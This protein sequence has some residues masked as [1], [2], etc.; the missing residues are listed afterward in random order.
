MDLGDFIEQSREATTPGELFDLLVRAA[1]DL[2]FER[3]AYGALTSHE[4]SDFPGRRGPAV[5]LNYPG[6]WQEHYFERGYHLIDP[7]VIRTPALERPYL[8]SDMVRKLDRDARERLI[9]DEAREAGLRSGISVPLHGPWGRVGVLSFASQFDDADPSPK[10]NHLNVLASQ[11]HIAFGELND[12]LRAATAIKLSTREAD[13]LRWTAEGKS[14]WDVG[15]IL[16][17]SENTANFHVKNAMKKLNTS[18]RTVA[19]LKAIRLNLLDLPYPW[20]HAS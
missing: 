3:L 19:V 8:W 10:V 2:G 1:T 14:A 11:F 17:I 20:R 18:S 5:I 16:G 6:D 7:V 13:C 15:M 4:A 12:S 9:F